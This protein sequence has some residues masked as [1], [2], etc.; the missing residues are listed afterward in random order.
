MLQVNAH[1]LRQILINLIDNAVKYGP[2]G[3]ISK[4]PCRSRPRMTTSTVAVTD[5][6]PGI[7]RRIANG[8]GSLT[9]VWTGRTTGRAAVLESA[10]RWHGSSLDSWMVRSRFGQPGWWKQIRRNLAEGRVDG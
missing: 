5:E 3:Q 7:R 6:G 9:Y 8:S 2:K 4:S 1:A 10:C